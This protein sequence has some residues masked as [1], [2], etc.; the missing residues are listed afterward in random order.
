MIGNYALYVA[1]LAAR[2]LLKIVPLRFAYALATGAGACA[3]LLFPIPR[4]DICANLA[5]VTREPASSSR[6]RSLAR[7]AFITDARNWVDTVRIGSLSDGEILRSVM[8]DG[9][10]RLD[11]AAAQGR[12]VVLVTLHLGNFDLV[13]QVL[14]AR[15]YSLTVPVERIRP[16]RLF[17]LLTEERRSRGINVV[18]LEEA[19]RA[20][21][22]ALRAGELVGIAGDRGAAGKT[23]EVEFFGMPAHLPKAAVSLARLTRAPL[24]VGVGLRSPHG[25]YRGYVSDEIPMART[26]NAAED[27]R[28]NTQRVARVLEDVIARN[29][30]Q[31]LMFTPLWRPANGG[32]ATMKHASEAAV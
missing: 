28:N 8:V 19:P 18:P 9:W 31:W 30:G 26:E 23:V 10:D 32:A 11:E 20:M 27:D 16:A 4:R 25:G 3:Y 5:V 1:L 29:P 24:L 2:V 22:R 14:A 6:V 15:G 12:G 17:S 7:E 21:V 13:G